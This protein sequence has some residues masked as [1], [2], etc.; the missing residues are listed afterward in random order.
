MP[1]AHTRCFI[2]KFEHISHL[3]LVFLFLILSRQML[4]GLELLHIYKDL[5]SFTFHCVK[6]VSIRTFCGLYFPA[7]RLTTKIYS[8]NL[9]IQ[10]R[11][12][13]IRTRKTKN[14]DTFYAVF[15]RCKSHVKLQMSQLNCMLSLTHCE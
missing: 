10:S 11:C 12:G 15:I 13:K 4:A 14:M 2:V 3:A 8:S 9:C 7:F 5:V 1:F 6:S